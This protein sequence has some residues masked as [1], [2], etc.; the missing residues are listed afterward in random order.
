MYDF[1]N[2]LTAAILILCVTVKLNNISH[3]IRNYTKKMIQLQNIIG[4]AN[5]NDYN[6]TWTQHLK[7]DVHIICA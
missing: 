5:D 6:F 3:N 1:D 4:R 2:L 7:S